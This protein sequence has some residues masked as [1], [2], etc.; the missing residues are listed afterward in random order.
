MPIRESLP[1]TH[2]S[3]TSSAAVTLSLP[4]D[5]DY[6]VLARSAAGHLGTRIGLS[7]EELG[8]LR[9]AVSEAC[10]LFLTGD[11]LT[12]T[13]ETIDCTFT[14]IGHALHVTVAA[15]IE[16]PGGP[17]VDSFGWHLLSA[18]V[19]ELHWLEDAEPGRVCVRLIKAAAVRGR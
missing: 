9:L 10:A 17:P 3:M 5:K 4:V 14:E 18:L 12:V 13:S 6:V 16:V 19:D 15:T 11:M 7:M 2:H 1:A 8:D